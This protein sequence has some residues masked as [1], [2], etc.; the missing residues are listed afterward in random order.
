MAPSARRAPIAFALLLCAL[1]SACSSPSRGYRPAYDDWEHVTRATDEATPPDDAPP[2]PGPDAG[3][4]DLQAWAAVHSPALRAAAL[5]WRAA[6]ERVPQVGSLPDPRLSF[7]YFLQEVQTRTGPMQWRVGVSQPLPWFGELDLAEEAALASAR[8]EGARFERERLAVAARVADAFAELAWL[9]EA[10]RVTAAHLEL[11]ENWE[12]VARSRYATGLGGEADVI[13]AQVELGK[14]DDRVRSLRDLRHPVAARLNAALDRAPDAPL[15]T[16]RLDGLPTHAVDGDAL[17]AALPSTSP[18]LL[19]FDHAIAAAEARVEL[20]ETDGY[21]DAALGLDWT[22]IGKGG[23]DALALTAGLSLPIFRGRVRAATGQ[24]EAELG[25]TRAE[26][27]QAAHRIEAELQLLLYRV[28]DAERRITLYR[29]SLLTKGQESVAVIAAAYQS[30]KAGFLDLI[31][32]E[33]V[34]L[35]FQLVTARAQADQAQALA[36]LDALTGVALPEETGP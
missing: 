31:D 24:A 18:E 35:E 2:E 25:A 29:D 23:D 6:L 12:E 16:P 15:P 21:P 19:A 22:R 13:R 5:R 26:R 7:G 17:A 1:A 36:A 28:R 30:G 10:A 27:A 11:V 34:L 4:D 9:D 32:A 20:A 8:A 14:L 3:L 33:R